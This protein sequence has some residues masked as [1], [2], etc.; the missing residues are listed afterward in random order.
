MLLWVHLFSASLFVVVV[1]LAI[2]SA[3]LRGLLFDMYTEDNNQPQSW[4]PHLH[5]WRAAPYQQMPTSW[6]L[7]CVA[8]IENCM[9]SNLLTLNADKT[10]FTWLCTWQQLS[11]IN[12][13]PLQMKDQFTPLLDTVRDL[14]IILNSE[15]SMDAHVWTVVRSC[16]SQPRQLC[17]IQKSQPTNALCTLAATFITNW[18]DYCNTVLHGVSASVIR[19]LQMVVSATIRL[20]V[21]AGECEHITP[22]LRDMLVYQRS[23]LLST[24]ST[25]LVQRTI[26]YFKDGCMLVVDTTGWTDLCSAERRSTLVLWTRTQLGR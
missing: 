13:A 12:S 20:V 23:L 14:G 25:A 2:N 22:V 17:S 15:L 24:V 4:H 3:T 18:L 8:D 1:V 11:K 16:F 6:L 7:A 21:G 26:M 19:W 5:R 10:E 9:W